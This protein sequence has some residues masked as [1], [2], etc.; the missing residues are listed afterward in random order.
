MDVLVLDTL[1]NLD[2]LIGILGIEDK[3]LSRRQFIRRQS[4][5][6]D[7]N[8]R[9]RSD[10]GHSEGLWV[11]LDQWGEPLRFLQDQYQEM[12]SI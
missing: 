3:S 11:P 5:V 1:L 6:D 2:R 7:R 12:P 10:S 8:L 4:Q 9:P